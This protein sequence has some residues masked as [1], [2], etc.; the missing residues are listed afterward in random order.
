MKASALL[1][2]LTV[3]KVHSSAPVNKNPGI[4]RRQNHPSL[5]PSYQGSACTGCFGFPSC[6][7]FTTLVSPAPRSS[8][9]R[10]LRIILSTSLETHLWGS[11]PHLGGNSPSPTSGIQWPLTDMGVQMPAP[12]SQV[13]IDSMTHFM[14]RS[15]LRYGVA[16]VSASGPTPGLCAPL[17][18]ALCNKSLSL[19]SQSQALILGNLT[20]E[21]PLQQVHL[22]FLKVA[23]LLFFLQRQNGDRMQK[24][25]NQLTDNRTCL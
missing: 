18:R 1:S 19:G 9:C 2:T 22:F 12:W 11:V 17:L 14:Y 23:P 16:A 15:N 5:P 20:Q 13:G 24:K 21:A 4:S 10:L 7:P 3:R 25:R 6:I 8:E